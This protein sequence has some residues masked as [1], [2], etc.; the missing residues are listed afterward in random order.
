MG[1]WL[2]SCD[3]EIGVTAAVKPWSFSFGFVFEDSLWSTVVRLMNAG[4]D[5]GTEVIP[6][7]MSSVTPVRGF[8]Y[9]M[10]FMEYGGVGEIFSAC[11]RTMMVGSLTKQ[12]I[13]S[14][15]GCA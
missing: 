8:A 1:L 12:L 4:T 15:K 3:Q 11:Q 13:L 6:G 2:F 7:V 9:L 10:R 5:V 14:A